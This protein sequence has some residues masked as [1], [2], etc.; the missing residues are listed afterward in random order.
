[1][2]VVALVAVLLDDGSTA[3]GAPAHTSP[4][5]TYERGAGLH[6]V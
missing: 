3:P 5:P 2:V 6:T 4:V 1:M